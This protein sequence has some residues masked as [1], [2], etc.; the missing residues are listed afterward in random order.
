MDNPK[1]KAILLFLLVVAFGVLLFGGHLMNRHKPP[2]PNVVVAD[3]KTLLTGKDVTEG[4]NYFYSRGGQHI[5]TIWGHGAYLAPDWSADYLHRMGLYLAARHLGKTQ[6]EASAFT[7]ADL[8]QL[9]APTRARISALVT[10][11]I[12]ANRF[13]QYCRHCN[14]WRRSGTGSSRRMR[15][16]PGTLPS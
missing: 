2:I 9:D 12:K 13:R 10:A 8:Q 11:E 5:G 16:P 7:Q 1:T 6:E 14:F 4:Q 15:M 3:G